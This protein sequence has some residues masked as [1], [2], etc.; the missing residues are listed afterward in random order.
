MQIIW[1]H[2]GNKNLVGKCQTFLNINFIQNTLSLY[3]WLKYEKYS[4]YSNENKIESNVKHM[5]HYGNKT[6]QEKCK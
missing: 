4:N 5:E 3:Y 1:M 6:L 2:Y